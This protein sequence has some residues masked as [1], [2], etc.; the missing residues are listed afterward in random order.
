MPATGRR[1]AC[2]E[3]RTSPCSRQCAPGA[4]RPSPTA[5]SIPPRPMWGARRR[6]CQPGH[7]LSAEV[8]HGVFTDD[9]EA[10][11]DT[12]LVSDTVPPDPGSPVSRAGELSEGISGENDSGTQTETVAAPL[13]VFSAA[14]LVEAMPLLGGQQSLEGCVARVAAPPAIRHRLRTGG[15][16]RRLRSGSIRLLDAA[17][18]LRPPS[19]LMMPAPMRRV[20][21]LEPARVAS[22][23]ESRDVVRQR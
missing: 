7:D 21:R 15:C 10:A 2:P 4:S 14:L 23:E 1:W 12:S 5:A 9:A 11:L 20:R 16:L 19:R 17:Q 13:T 6:V 18:C 8:S 22:G 3:G